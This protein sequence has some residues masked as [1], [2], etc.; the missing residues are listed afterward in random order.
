MYDATIKII[1]IFVSVCVLHTFQQIIPG[2]YS[3]CCNQIIV[4]ADVLHILQQ[5]II[6]AYARSALNR[7]SYRLCSAHLKKRHHTGFVRRALNRTSHR[8]VFY[9]SYN[10]S[11]YLLLSAT[12]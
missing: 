2:F 5:I 11:S 7:T 9:A 6:P 12:L 3:Q 10:R 1:K 4:P 8:L